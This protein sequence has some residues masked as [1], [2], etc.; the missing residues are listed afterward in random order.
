MV[1]NWIAKF[2]WCGNCRHSRDL[3]ALAGNCGFAY[4]GGKSE[5]WAEYCG[6]K[7]FR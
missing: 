3:H 6:C 1:M 2:R 4:R 5:G 7:R